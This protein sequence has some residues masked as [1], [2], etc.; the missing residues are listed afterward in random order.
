MTVQRDQPPVPETDGPPQGQPAPEAPNAPP[1]DEL[2]TLK[3]ELADSEE[4]A[5]EY[6]R[7]AQR[8]QADFINYRRRM[9]EERA[10]QARDA[11]LSAVLHVEHR[12]R[13]GL[14]DGIDQCELVFNGQRRLEIPPLH[15]G[16]R[17][18]GKRCK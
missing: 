9:E 15:L 14:G 5:E 17:W 7:L 8:A 16:A 2:E 10:Q 6:K 13:R 12:V 11:G 1:T 3:A 4:K 18:R